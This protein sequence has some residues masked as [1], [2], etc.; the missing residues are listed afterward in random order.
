MKNQIIKMYVDN[1]KTHLLIFLILLFLITTF[2]VVY[3]TA[4]GVTEVPTNVSNDTPLLFLGNMNIAPVIY[5]DGTT[6]KGVD[7]DIVQ[8][9][10]QHMSRPVEIRAMNWS[11]AQV[12]VAR[13]EADALIQI[14]PTEERLKLFDFSDPLLESQFTI[15]T[16]SDTLGISGISS[17]FGLR[18]GV[19]SGG[20]P[21]KV[22]GK[23]PHIQ[24]TDI[25]GFPGGFKELNEGSLDAVVVDYRVGSYILAEN[26][27][28]NIRVTGEPVAISN[29]SFAVQKGDTQL[30]NEINSALQK[31]KADGTYQNIIDTWKPTEGIFQTQEQITEGIYHIV[32]IFLFIVFLIAFIW[33]L[34]IKKD[35]TR[36]KATEEKLKES[37]ERFF[38]LFELATDAILVYDIDLERFVDANRNAEKLFGYEKR[39]LIN[40][41]PAHF[42][43]PDQPNNR[44][45]V[46]SV[47]E[48]N[49]RVMNGEEILFDRVIRR[50]NGE[51]RYCEVRQVKLPFADRRLIRTSF[52]DI[53]D[54][55]QA[56]KELIKYRF[57][58][59]EL[60][61][62][63]TRDL[64]TAKEQ[65]E[66]ANKKLNLLS[67]ITRHDINNE[68]Q[69]IFGY[70]GFVKDT[71]LGPDL[72][73]YIE[74]VYLSALNIARQIAFTRDYQDI[75][76]HS[77]VWQ[78]VSTIITQAVS[79][80][81]ISQIKLHIGIS[82]IFVYADPLM[83]KVFYNLI[84]NARRYGD[85]ITRIRFFG[86]EGREG[87]TI[88]C[89]DDGVGIP[90]EFKSKI[91]THEY[92]THTG[93]GLN[94]S[95][96]I[97]SITGLSIRECGVP[98]E[99]A[100]FE[101]LVPPGKFRKGES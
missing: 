45:V 18:V 37:E 60:V 44:S 76:V 43:P 12:L 61:K 14:N 6:P 22:L 23:Y 51:T 67:S 93:F 90:D 86:I 82:G 74:N 55:K 94:L 53:T 54:R 79:T 83:E 39:E 96:E 42:Y 58:L 97:L 95:R 15:F 46:K 11:E 20:L 88:I 89:E 48:H 98:G 70:L 101:I 84:D 62:E 65:A 73:R 99:G 92:Y 25:P 9:L 17:L 31:I 8:A 5:L 68:I 41:G 3:A 21:Q 2:S 71:D 33:I 28:Q 13:G 34:T 66:N 59:E 56:E 78:D 19:E 75:G 72:N 24:L 7:V 87:Y 49:E 29:S 35:L 91:F 1:M 80:L 81:D 85:T 27:I 10:A 26:N 57:H 100:R 52:I 40:Y 16:R 4:G 50:K 30:L 77:P 63:R 69:I 38:I 32:I 36:R 47:Q 64:Q